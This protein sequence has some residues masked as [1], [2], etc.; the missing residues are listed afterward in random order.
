MNTDEA[1]S[2]VSAEL[3]ANGHDEVMAEGILFGLMVGYGMD[4]TAFLAL[5]GNRLS[6]LT[7]QV[8]KAAGRSVAAQPG[9][10][11]RNI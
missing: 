7:R 6:H 1:L 9:E 4:D 8:L 5:H 10:R 11:P 3:T 2:A